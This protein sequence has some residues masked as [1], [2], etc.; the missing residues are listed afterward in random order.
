MAEER[1]SAC[2]LEEEEGGGGN[3]AMPA[4]GA[5][6][7]RGR[8]WRRPTASGKTSN[9]SKQGRALGPPGLGIHGCWP[10]RGDRL[11][12]GLQGRAP[13]D[14]GQGASALREEGAAKGVTPWE[15]EL[16]LKHA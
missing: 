15:E 1:R 5:E 8:R 12:G 3:G 14:R 2:L 4:G 13:R 7:E 10:S 11:A 9:Q 6:L 16:L